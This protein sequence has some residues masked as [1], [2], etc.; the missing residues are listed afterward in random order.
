MNT[1]KTPWYAFMGNVPCHLDYPQ[2]TM[3]EMV[4]AVAGKYPGYIAY[5]FMGSHT[6]YARMVREI[7]ECARALKALG[8]RPDDR[9]T[10]CMPNAPQTIIMFYAVNVIGAIAN[11]VHPLSAEGEIE[12]YLNDSECWQSCPC[13]MAL[14]WA[15]AFI[16]C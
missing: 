1:V 3:I 11:M 5:D 4:E 12:F 8:I 6:T 10:I 13:S 14:A 16:P 15:C 9:V 2:G 7:H